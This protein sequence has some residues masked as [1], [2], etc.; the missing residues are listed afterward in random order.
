[1]KDIEK[2]VL[3]HTSDAFAEDPLR[4]LRG[5][6]WLG[7]G[8]DRKITSYGHEAAG[9]PMAEKFLDR[10]GIHPSIKERVGKL[11]VTHMAHLVEPTPSAVRR[12]QARPPPAPGFDRGGAR[13]LARRRGE[14]PPRPSEM[15]E[16]VRAWQKAASDLKVEVCPPARI[17]Q[18]RDLIALGHSP[19]P[20]MGKALDRAYEAQL[21]GAFSDKPGGI[22][23]I[24]SL[25]SAVSGS[26]GTVRQQTARG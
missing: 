13:P 23:F 24:G 25:P 5:C 11:V 21:E 8:P 1:M 22:K 16:N 17:L 19:G 15:P 10:L 9:G 12:P 20:E 3:R 26:T 18:G 4:P 6:R 7:D 14:S 2:R